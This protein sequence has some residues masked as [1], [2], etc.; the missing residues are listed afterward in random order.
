M[1]QGKNQL[2][3]MVCPKCLTTYQMTKKDAEGKPTC[4]YCDVYLEP[5]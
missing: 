2:I 4:D 1:K 3:E 5:A